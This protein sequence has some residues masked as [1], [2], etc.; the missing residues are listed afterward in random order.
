M[1]GKAEVYRLRQ[2]LDATFKRASTLRSDPEIQSDFARYLC[3]LVSGF[4]E[5][6]VAE[7]IMEHARNHSAPTIQRFVELRIQQLTN[8]KTQ[9]L[10]E[11]LGTLNPEWRQDLE[12]FVV[13][14]KKDALDSI[15]SL[16]N[17]ISHGYSVGVTFARIQKYYEQVKVVVDRVATLC[18]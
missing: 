10:Q 8:V 11:V 6:A 17:R 3:I 9:R 7:L 12:Q 13:D 4:I 1:T 2:M 15:V 5:Q 14:E 18:T 16:R